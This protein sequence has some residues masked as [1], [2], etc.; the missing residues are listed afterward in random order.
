MVLLCIAQPSLWTRESFTVG[1]L[2]WGA[3]LQEVDYFLVR[4]EF[5]LT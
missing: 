4:L 3:F 1:T 2:T 5:E